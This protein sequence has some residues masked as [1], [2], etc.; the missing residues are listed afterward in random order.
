MGGN[1]ATEVAFNRFLS[2]KDVNPD[3]ISCELAIKTNDACLDKEH[4]LCIQDT[5]QLTYPT[6]SFKK[7]NF[8]PTGDENT[9]GLFVH[10]GIIVDASNRDVI[11]VSSVITWIRG[12]QLSVQTN[13]N[14]AIEE[15]ESIRWINTALSARENITNAAMITVIGD[16]ESD[17]FEVFKRVPDEKTHLIVRAS[18]DR[19]LE[20]DEK[21]S[22]LL[23]NTKSAGTYEI[24]LPAITGKRK[25][26]TATLE[27]KYTPISLPNQEKS[28]VFIL[29]FC[30]GNIFRAVWRIANKLDIIDDTCHKIIE[31]SNTDSDVVYLALD[32]RT[33]FSHNEK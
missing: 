13:K 20:T 9:K 12:E 28:I 30:Y 32:Y 24:E 1:R 10:P 11:G 21:I 17:I 25:A 22:E 18:H 16:R 14:R 2:N 26:R 27:I 15:K 23:S 5:V 19:K 6:Q 4:V 31:N 8:G 33:D 7:N 3:A 29:C